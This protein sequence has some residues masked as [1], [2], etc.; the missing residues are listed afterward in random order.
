MRDVSNVKQ[1]RSISIDKIFSQEVDGR[2]LIDGF[3]GQDHFTWLFLKTID[4]VHRIDSVHHLVD[5]IIEDPL[6]LPTNWHKEK[7]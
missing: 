4:T 1:L 3:F 5:F 7:K 2:F 6:K